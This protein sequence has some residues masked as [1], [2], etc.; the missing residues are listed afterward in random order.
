[1]SF[2]W[3]LQDGDPDF[4]SAIAALKRPP[5]HGNLRPPCDLGPCSVP[6]TRT[7]STCFS[8][9]QSSATTL[10]YAIP[11][12]FTLLSLS[13]PIAPPFPSSALFP[14]LFPHN[15]YFINIYLRLWSENGHEKNK[16]CCGSVVILSQALW[17]LQVKI[18]L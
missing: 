15:G 7:N 5:E 9:C 6:P 14:T 3:S 17:W 4:T 18:A 8:L 10:L 13:L 1:M 12:S 2:P 16:G 11:A